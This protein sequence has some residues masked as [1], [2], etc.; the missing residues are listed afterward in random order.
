MYRF[1]VLAF[2]FLFLGTAHSEYLSATRP[3]QGNDCM[4]LA[5][6]S[7]QISD[8]N[9]SVPVRDTPSASG[10]ILAE[11]ATVLIVPTSQ[12]PAAGFLQVLLS[13]GRRGWVQA[14]I[15][16]PWR[17][18]TNPNRHC[19]PSIMSNGTIGFDVK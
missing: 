19:I 7:E 10:R 2:P 1:S 15:L 13:D 9:L 12:K 3:L 5:L 16:K 14:A 18:S 6:T 17:S 4:Q 11:A 8:P